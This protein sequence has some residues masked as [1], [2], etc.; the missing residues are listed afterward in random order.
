[1]MLL[2]EQAAEMQAQAEVDAL[3]LAILYALALGIALPDTLLI[4]GRE[5]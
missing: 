4:F 3:D 2:N 1:M 5:A